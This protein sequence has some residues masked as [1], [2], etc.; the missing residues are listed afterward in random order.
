MFNEMITIQG[1]CRLKQ[2]KVKT[3]MKYEKPEH[4]PGSY[5]QDRI[6]LSISL[7]GQKSQDTLSSG[8]I[9]DLD[10]IK[11]VS[12]YLA[13]QIVPEHGSGLHVMRSRS[14]LEC[15][16]NRGGPFS[17]LGDGRGRGVDVC[18]DYIFYSFCVVRRSR[19]ES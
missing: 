16:G 12:V 19:L 13:C 14:G 11:S 17:C 2:V 8:A 7:F 1:F 10:H 9:V 6:M 18:G 5:G 15:V 4:G 3:D